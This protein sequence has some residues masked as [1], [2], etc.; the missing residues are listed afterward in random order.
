VAGLLRPPEKI[1]EI[2]PTPKIPT[3][4]A[5]A[6]TAD[7]FTIGPCTQFGGEWTN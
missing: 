7:F 1:Q 2:S 6:M 4:K 3:H 5:P